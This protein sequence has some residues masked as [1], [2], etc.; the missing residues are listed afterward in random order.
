MD[1]ADVHWSSKY[2]P[3][4]HATDIEELYNEQ[5]NSLI[6]KFHNL[7]LQGSGWELECIVNVND[8]N[9]DVNELD[10]EEA[11]NFDIGKF[12]RSKRGLIVPQNTDDYCFL[13]ACAIA[14]LKH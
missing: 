7:Q 1:R 8:G 13:D 2:L 3:L 10:R 12:W 6:E 11:P 9:V 4:F 5:K 14:Q